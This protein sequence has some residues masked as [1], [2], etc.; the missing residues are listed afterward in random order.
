MP[1]VHSNLLTMHAKNIVL[2]QTLAIF[3]QVGYLRSKRFRSPSV[4][5]SHQEKKAQDKSHPERRR[6]MITLLTL[7]G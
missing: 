1:F 2:H 6:F 4:P 3:V 5:R 7:I